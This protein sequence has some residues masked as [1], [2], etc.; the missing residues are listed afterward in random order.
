MNDVLWRRRPRG[1]TDGFL[2]GV[3]F[4]DGRWATSTGSASDGVVLSSGG[5]GG[6]D[7]AVNQNWWLHPLPPPGPL[8]LVLRCSALGIDETQVT[9]DGSPIRSAAAQVVEFWPWTPP[10][11]P[12]EQVPTG[13]G[14]PADS[15]FA[16]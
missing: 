8:T 15:W 11:P 9:V 3:E 2:F 6:G 14:V 10:T 16:R 12:E 1:D 4:P 13:P 7:R 5:G